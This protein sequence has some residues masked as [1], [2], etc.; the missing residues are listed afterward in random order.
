MAELKLELNLGEL[1]HPAMIQGLV[2]FIEAFPRD[3]MAV[4]LRLLRSDQATR[5]LIAEELGEQALKEQKA[6][7]EAVSLQR[8]TDFMSDGPAGKSWDEIMIEV[9]D[10]L[11]AT[12][13]GN[14]LVG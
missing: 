2:E 13:G 3:R 1:V 6:D 7:D 5:C 8:A 4:I 14:G 10:R 9:L 11:E 12:P